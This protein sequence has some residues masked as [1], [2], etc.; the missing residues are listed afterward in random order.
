RP[1]GGW[2]SGKSSPPLLPFIGPA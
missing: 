1:G 2:L